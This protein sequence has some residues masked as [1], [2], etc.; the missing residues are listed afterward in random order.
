MSTSFIYFFCVILDNYI[1]FI[2]ILQDN[3]LI[4]LSTCKRLDVQSK[5]AFELVVNGF[6]KSFSVKPV[7][8]AATKNRISGK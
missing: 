7:C 2:L 4:V 8:L 3:F 1:L 5:A 6:R